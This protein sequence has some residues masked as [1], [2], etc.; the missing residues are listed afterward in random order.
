MAYADLINTETE[1]L[2][3]EEQFETSLNIA[4]REGWHGALL[5]VELTPKM[6][7]A[8]PLDEEELLELARELGARIRK[9]VRGED[10]YLRLEPHRYLVWLQKAV[11]DQLDRIARR[12]VEELEMPVGGQMYD[13]RI[14]I[15]LYPFDGGSLERLQHAC[16]QAL[17]QAR[18]RNK[19]VQIFNPEG[20]EAGDSRG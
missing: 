8:G 13:V 19:T 20:E 15:S 3:F 9:V 10:L 14:G 2:V 5:E 7:A 12:L 6:E 4:R 11:A 16:S 17:A 18:A 1:K